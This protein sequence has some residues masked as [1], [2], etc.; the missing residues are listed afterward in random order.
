MITQETYVTPTGE[1]WV[2]IAEEETVT[3]ASA[4]RS[5]YSRRKLR[6]RKSDERAQ[7][8]DRIRNQEYL[9]HIADLIEVFDLARVVARE[10]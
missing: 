4:L 1:V 9:E 8:H 7:P 6:Y 2:C 3:V 10:G 5:M